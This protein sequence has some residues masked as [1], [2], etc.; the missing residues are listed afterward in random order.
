MAK[1]H[2]VSKKEANIGS[3]IAL[4]IIGLATGCYAEYR[5]ISGVYEGIEAAQADCAAKTLIE[6]HDAYEKGLADGKAEK[7]ESES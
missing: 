3:W 7:E 2:I 6:V 1:K 5:R 4:G